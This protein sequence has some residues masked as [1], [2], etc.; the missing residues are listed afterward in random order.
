MNNKTTIGIIR[1]LLLIIIAIVPLTSHLL[2]KD[3]IQIVYIANL[4]GPNSLQGIGGLKGAT[5]AI[6]DFKLDS[7]EVVITSINMAEYKTDDGLF[8]KIDSLKPDLL[9]G[10]ASS[11]EFIR[12][13]P[14]IENHKIPCLGISVSLNQETGK[15][16]AFFRLSTTTAFNASKAATYADNQLHFRKIFILYSDENSAYSESYADSFKEALSN[17]YVCEKNSISKFSRSPNMIESYDSILLVGPPQ[18]AGLAIQKIR[19]ISKDLPIMMTAWSLSPI[20]LQYAGGFDQHLY[21]MSIYSLNQNIAYLDFSNRY[22]NIYATFPN[23]GAAVA[24]ESIAM[25]DTILHEEDF[26]SHDLLSIL[27]KPREIDGPFD[28]YHLDGFG[29]IIRPIYLLEYHDGIYIEAAR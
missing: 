2:S 19:S 12:I 11:T 23:I 15:K 17:D 9:L 25:L 28:H 16:D 1:I 6:K 14:Y 7:K 10:P 5:M 13:K 21:F 27:Q 22:Q 3:P 26:K 29:D 18:T 4:T 20:T 8:K 24:Y